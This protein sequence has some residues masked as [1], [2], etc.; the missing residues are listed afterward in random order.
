[1]SKTGFAGAVLAIVAGAGWTYNVNYATKTTLGRIGDLRGS[2]ASERERIQVLRVE[3]AWLNN[4]ERLARLSD[5][6]AGALGLVPMAP[7]TFDLAGALPEPP[8]TVEDLDALLL[9]QLADV[10]AAWD[11]EP[12]TGSVLPPPRPASWSAE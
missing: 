4:P 7:I 8:A 3:W 1:M 9:A 6:H 10:G 11:L 2:I 5:A 12:P